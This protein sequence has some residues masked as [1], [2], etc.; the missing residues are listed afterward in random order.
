MIR[1]VCLHVYAKKVVEVSTKCN[2]ITKQRM[3]KISFYYNEK[4]FLEG[5]EVK[6]K[7]SFYYVIENETGKFLKFFIIDEAKREKRKKSI[8]LTILYIICLL[9]EKKKLF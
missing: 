4:K 1:F 5:N 6:Q 7:P 9:A 2:F 8:T 3:K